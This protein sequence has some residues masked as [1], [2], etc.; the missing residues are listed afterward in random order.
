MGMF[1][2]LIVEDDKN[3]RRLF[4]AVLEAGHYSVSVASDGNEALSVLDREHID[5][6]ILD[7]MMPEMDGYTFT[8]LLRDG[9][10]TIPILMVSARQLPE[11]KRQGFLAGADDYM[12]KPA[13][14]E[15]M[16]LRIKALLRRA[17]IV[18][19]R[20]IIVGDVIL[21]YDTMSVTR[22]D[23]TQVLPN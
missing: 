2:I 15:E 23:E 8:S 1:H 20:R 16:L 22:K 13:D 6:I 9:N 17:Q 18:N 14:M 7:I 12:T 11:D 19:E 21:D 4:K 5:L 3:T 10:S